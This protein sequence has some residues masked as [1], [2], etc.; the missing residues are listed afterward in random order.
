MN[1]CV[2]YSLQSDSPNSINR[3]FIENAI[4]EAIKSINEEVDFQEAVRFDKD[5]KDVP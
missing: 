3:T 5:T 1:R 4:K 2:F